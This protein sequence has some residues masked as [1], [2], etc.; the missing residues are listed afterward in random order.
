MAW[1]TKESD[2]G[3]RG[4]AGYVVR[5]RIL[6]E[7]LDSS[8]ITK[9]IA[10][11]LDEF[12]CGALKMYQ[13]TV[14]V[15]G[16]GLLPDLLSYQTS[17]GHWDNITEPPGLK[18]FLVGHYEAEKSNGNRL[19]FTDVYPLIKGGKQYLGFLKEGIVNL[20]TADASLACPATLALIDRLGYEKAVYVSQDE[21]RV[22][23]G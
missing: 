5:K 4:G 8:V 1:G 3:I 22:T 7:A 20:K 14:D 6:G 17:G 11:Q 9:E 18:N 21:P 10:F 12:L 23:A 16:F 13:A 15:N 2:G 19:F